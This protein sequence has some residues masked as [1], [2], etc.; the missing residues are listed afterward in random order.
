MTL[1]ADVGAGTRT[2]LW[3]HAGLRR[4]QTGLE[5]LLEDPYPLARLIGACALVRRE[6]RGAHVREDH[7][8]TDPQLD[9]MHTIVDPDGGVSFER[10]D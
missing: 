7:P 5:Q 9:A 6:S 3:Q 4:T 10:W 8:R 2:A 1:V